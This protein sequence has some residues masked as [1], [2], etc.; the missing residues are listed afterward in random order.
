MIRSR[1]IRTNFEVR[2]DQVKAG[3]RI[4]DSLF[5]KWYYMHIFYEV[6]SSQSL[7]DIKTARLGEV[8]PQKLFDFLSFN[9]C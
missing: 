1:P 3:R 6:Y 7:N 5:N 2:K 8:S 9:F 4:M